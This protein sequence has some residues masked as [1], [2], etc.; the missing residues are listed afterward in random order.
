[1]SGS[2]QRAWAVQWMSP[3]TFLFGSL[4]ASCQEAQGR[5]RIRAVLPTPA[6]LCARFS[7]HVS[8]C[9]HLCFPGFGE[10]WE[11]IQPNAGTEEVTISLALINEALISVLFSLRLVPAALPH[12]AAA[13]TVPVLPLDTLQWKWVMFFPLALQDNLGEEDALKMN[14]IF[15]LCG[16]HRKR[17]MSCKI[18]PCLWFWG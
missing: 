16:V 6:H 10:Q 13:R 12:K 15:Q 9:L 5:L 8:A 14:A 4:T 11:H 1:M 17:E 2:L 18:I 3:A 7:W